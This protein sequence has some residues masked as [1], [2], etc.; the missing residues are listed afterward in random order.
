MKT[1]EIGEPVVLF[2]GVKEIHGFSVIEKMNDEYYKISKTDG[3]HGDYLIKPAEVMR[4]KKL[5]DADYVEIEMTF[6]EFAKQY[7]NV[8]NY[9]VIENEVIDTSELGILIESN[10]VLSGEDRFSLLKNFV[11][12]PPVEKHYEIKDGTGNVLETTGGHLTWFNNQW[13]ETQ[14]RLEQDE[15]V[16]LIE[17]AMKVV[18]C[19]VDETE[20]Y[21]ANGQLNHNSYVVPGGKAIPFYSSI[22]LYLEGKTKIVAKDPTL[23]NEYQIALAEWK[24]AGGKKT[25][26]EKPEKPKSTKENETTVGYEVTAYTKKNKTAPPD[27]RTPFRIVFSQGLFDEECWLD[28]CIKYGIV[29]TSGAYNEITAF[30][31][32][33]GKFYKTEWLDILQSSEKIYNKIK[34]LLI[35]K[36]TVKLQLAE[37]SIEDEELIE[38]NDSN[39][40]NESSED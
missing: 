33:K 20:C 26:V 28:Q 7:L 14:A 16:S 8:T 2:N 1:F 32:D 3:S 35:E 36:M 38:E 15:S 11:I 25:G 5:H 23:E 37:Y 9:D 27:R 29:K 21:Y 17:E 40:I 30:E 4:K 39:E 12:K 6:D 10:D 18:D 34:D 13:I 22:R 31:N 19:S 24:A